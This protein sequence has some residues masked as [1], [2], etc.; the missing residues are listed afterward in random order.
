MSFNPGDVVLRDFTLS[1]AGGSVDVRRRIKDFS[2]YENIKTPYTTIVA[3]VLDTTDMLNSNLG[4]DGKNNVL[5]ASF[6]QPGQHIYDGTWQ[7][8]AVEKGRTLENQRTAEYKITGYSPHMQR[9]PKVQKSFKEQPATAVAS[10]LIN[11]FLQPLKSVII[12]AEARSVV[13]NKMMP[14]NINGISIHKAI[15]S[16]LA[17]AASTKD[18]SSAY[19][20]F[21]N[22]YNI[23]IDTLE[24]LMN[25]AVGSQVQTFYQRPM[26]QDFLRDVALQPFIIL[27]MKEE[28]RVDSTSNVLNDNQATNVL[29]LFSSKFDKGKTGGAATYLNIPYNI[30]RPPT[31][32]K[33]VL[34]A[35]KKVAGQFDSQSATIQVS[36][37]TDVTVG[38]GF[39]VQTLAPAGDTDIVKLDNISGPL[40]ATE[41]RHTVKMTEKKMM[42][43]STIKGAKGNL[44]YLGLG[45]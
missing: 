42:G 7:I 22:Q 27:A 29:D 13:G 32:L 18:Q 12:G 1:G 45:G 36:L 8:M 35:R 6:S 37:A 26:G 4:L 10:S 25:K 5:T 23:V 44:D 16:V 30:L 19:V 41:V 14:Y 28:S 17:R 20:Y 39:N 11:E 38:L 3:T 2:I 34:A 24:N 40:L 21:E 31:F 9:A 43:M 33:D 15:R